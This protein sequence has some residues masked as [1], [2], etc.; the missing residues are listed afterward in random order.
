M[1]AAVRQWLETLA[2]VAGRH[3]AVGSGFPLSDPPDR[4][5]IAELLAWLSVPEPDAAALL[6]TFPGPDTDPGLWHALAH[7]ELALRSGMGQILPPIPWP[8]APAELGEAGRYFYA[9][10]YLLTL[11]ATLK[12]HQEL[13]I[14]E[15]ISRATFA[16]L[17]THLALH[18][19]RF[20]TGGLDQRHWLSRHFRGTLFRLGRLQFDRALLS[21]EVFDGS[22]HH[23]LPTPETPQPG[24]SV[25]EIHVPG[26]GPL[27]PALCEESYA[28]APAFFARYFAERY[29]IGICHSWLL[30]RQLAQSLAP[31]ANIVQF[32]RRYRLFPKLAKADADVL[33]FV[34]DIPSGETGHSL[35][36]GRTTL[37]RA[38]TAHLHQGKHWYT[39]SGWTSLP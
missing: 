23:G 10:L 24:A 26:D 33:A 4:A 38:I 12:W 29:D 3:T 39:A 7:G 16:D 35:P 2:D 28:A 9:H 37:E 25:L 34:F 21:A 32:Q 20:R 36:Q 11:P 18:R 27:D 19:R 6:R 8:Q 14:P 22:Q 13:G 15:N 5:A 31:A 30:D 17:S 1:S